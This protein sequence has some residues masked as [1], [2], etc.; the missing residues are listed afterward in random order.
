VGIDR[1]QAI[2]KT[3]TSIATNGTQT[4]TYALTSIPGANRSK[5]RGEERFAVFS[6]EDYQAPESQLASEYIQIWPVADGSIV[7]IT[8]NQLV[9]YVV[10]QLTVTLND[11]YP[12]STTYVQVY[13][14]NPQLGVTGTIIPGSS[15]IISESVPQNRILTLKNYESL[16]DSDGRWTMELLTV[17]TFGIDRLQYMS[18]DIKRSIDMNA[19]VTTIE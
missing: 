5:V 3:Q 8:Q 19:T 10:P 4:L 14:G 13:K 16:F 6:L 12:S 18:F 15:L 17:T 9:R 2:L 11:L 1:T 7:G